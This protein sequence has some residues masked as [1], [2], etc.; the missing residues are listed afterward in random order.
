MKMRGKCSVLLVSAIAASLISAPAAAARPTCEE[1]AG[2]TR[3]ET[4]GSVSIKAVPTT[5]AS[6]Q[7]RRWPPARSGL[8]ISW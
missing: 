5:S 4:N 1:S 8:M 7:P 2:L 6:D 3:C